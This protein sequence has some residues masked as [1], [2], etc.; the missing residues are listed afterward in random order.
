MVERNKNAIRLLKAPIDLMIISKI[1]QDFGVMY[2]A[3]DDR[4]AVKRPRIYGALLE[5]L[6]RLKIADKHQSSMA[7][8]LIQD[9]GEPNIG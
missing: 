6:V 4:M 3:T 5:W 2:P 8:V 1:S 9:L 7:A